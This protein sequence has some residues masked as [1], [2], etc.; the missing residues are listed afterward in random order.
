MSLFDV[1]QEYF[2][3]FYYYN[4]VSDLEIGPSYVLD[5]IPEPKDFEDTYGIQFGNETF[6]EFCDEEQFDPMDIDPDTSPPQNTF[7]YPQPPPPPQVTFQVPQS[8]QK[9]FHP[10]QYQNMF[11]NVP[12]PPHPP[13]P[14]VYRQICHPMSNS[15]EIEKWMI[16]VLEMENKSND[17]LRAQKGFIEIIESHYWSYRTKRHFRPIQVIKQKIKR[18]FKKNV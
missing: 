16:E 18:R 7:Q 11:Q 3:D 2:N 9:M 14:S 5:T 8:L 10:Q 17:Q 12:P 1:D 4:D 6:D 13:L 15:S